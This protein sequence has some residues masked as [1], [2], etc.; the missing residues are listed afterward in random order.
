MT[1]TKH[2]RKLNQFLCT[3]CIILKNGPTQRMTLKRSIWILLWSLHQKMYKKWHALQQNDMISANE[4]QLF[5]SIWLWV[6]E[7]PESPVP[8]VGKLIH[9]QHQAWP[10]ILFS[11][12]R[13]ERLYWKGD[14]PSSCW[15]WTHT[16]T[17]VGFLSLHL[18]SSIPKASPN[19]GD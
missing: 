9:E 13:G 17:A 6:N 11:M 5:E 1:E 15:A 2:H 7:V 3:I 14:L 10:P 12:A 4:F 19:L 16:P 8:H 18:R